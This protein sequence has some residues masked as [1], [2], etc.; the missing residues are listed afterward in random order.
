MTIARHRSPFTV[1]CLAL[2]LAL[3]H[4]TPVQAQAANQL[5]NGMNGS[6]TTARGNDGVGGIERAK[7]PGVAPGN[8]GPA[9]PN[10]FGLVTPIAPTPPAPGG[11]SQLSYTGW[12]DLGHGLPGRSTSPA[13]EL[14]LFTQVQSALALAV[15]GGLP[16][17]EVIMVVGTQQQ[18]TPYKGGVLVPQ[19]DVLIS[20][21]SLNAH[22]QLILPLALLGLVP[23]QVEIYAQAWMPDQSNIRGYSATNAI[24]LK[25]P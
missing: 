22:G 3:S 4:A 8:T 18:L 23:P 24:A 2:L 17:H 21:L 1:L 19:P 25:M 6:G 11:S 12:L 20:G 10:Q 15:T 9:S 14:V 7:K 16:G 5:I 13:L